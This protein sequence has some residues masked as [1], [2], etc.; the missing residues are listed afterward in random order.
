MIKAVQPISM[1][2]SWFID[3]RNDAKRRYAAT[4]HIAAHDTA[5]PGDGCRYDLGDGR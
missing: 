1:K 2:W 4:T 5:V 3:A